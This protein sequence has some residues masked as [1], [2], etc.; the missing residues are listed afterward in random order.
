M[1]SPY[2]FFLINS[3]YP[4]L[5]QF[6]SIPHAPFPGLRIVRRFGSFSAR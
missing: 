5:L 2:S 3:E 1:I 6:L 4:Q